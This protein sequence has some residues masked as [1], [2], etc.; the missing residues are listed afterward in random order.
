MKLRPVR[1]VVTGLDAEG[2]STVVLDA[3]ATNRAEAPSWPGMGVTLLWMTDEAPADNSDHCD[4]ADRP[5]RALPP[6]H[7]TRFS[8]WQ[9]PPVSE[10]RD[11]SPDQRAR[12]LGVD[13][14]EAHTGGGRRHPGMHA[15]NTLDYLVVLSGEITLLLETGEVTLHTGDTLVDRGVIHAWENRGATAALCAVFNVDALPLTRFPA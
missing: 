5:F 11:L 15:T 10:L 1:R 9:C 3:P 14:I 12:A 2:R 7:G 13:M 8:L 4:G 6:P